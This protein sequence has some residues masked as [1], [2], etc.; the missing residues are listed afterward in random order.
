MSKEWGYKIKRMREIIG[1]KQEVVADALGIKQNSYSDIESG[2][3]DVSD[4]RLDQIAEILGTTADAIKA[5]DD[6]VIYN[7]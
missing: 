4:E 1:V 5:H 6:K 3:S 2:L 7:S